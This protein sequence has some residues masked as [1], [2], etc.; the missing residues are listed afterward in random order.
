MVN[1]DEYISVMVM[2]IVDLSCNTGSVTPGL[3]GQSSI[4]T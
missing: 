2:H 4:R 1:T 3:P